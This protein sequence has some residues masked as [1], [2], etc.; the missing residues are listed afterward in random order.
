M[1]IRSQIPN[2]ITLGNL[3]C[4]VLAILVC[5]N[6]YLATHWDMEPADAVLL[7][8]GIALL[9]DFLDGAAARA[10]KATSPMGAQLDSLSDLVTFG[11]L[12][13]ILTFLIFFSTL[14]QPLD[15]G[16]NP[17]SPFFEWP[18]LL[19]FTA[20]LI[21]L[22]VAY[23][24]AK[25][26]IDDRPQDVFYGLPSPANGIFFTALFWLSTQDNPDPLFKWIDH[27][28]ALPGTIILFSFL[29]VSDLPLLS[30]KFRSFA[31]GPNLSRYL[32]LGISLVLLIVWSVKAVPA[33]MVVYFLLSLVDRQLLNRRTE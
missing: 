14:G 9:C 32:L 29:M 7:L 21:P 33:I 20:L 27:P 31:F 6:P 22:A 8:V 19:G 18:G 2:L 3:A 25:F 28:Y 1:S 16:G 15:V 12:P 24:L 30:L 10:L 26:N 17:Q 11:V 4:G 23:R 13:G 5:F